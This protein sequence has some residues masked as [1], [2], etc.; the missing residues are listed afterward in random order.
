MNAV[1]VQ[2]PNSIHK[3]LAELAR[4]EGISVDQLIT[5]AVVEKT[6]ALMTLNYLEERAKRG[7]WEKFDEFLACVPDVEP[8]EYDKL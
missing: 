7:S 6:A 3:Q 4:K 2:L 8:E 1:N 5:T